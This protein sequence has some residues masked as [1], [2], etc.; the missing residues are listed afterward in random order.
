MKY[1]GIEISVPM[2]F[3]L[4]LLGIDIWLIYRAY[5]DA[6][7]S[8]IWIAILSA[9]SAMC[10]MSS[11][12]AILR[13]SKWI[14]DADAPEWPDRSDILPQGAAPKAKDMGLTHIRN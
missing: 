14:P 2:A 3:G 13:E 4:L 6:E 1:L 11:V 10:L 7:S 9:S 8:P 12:E 5:Q